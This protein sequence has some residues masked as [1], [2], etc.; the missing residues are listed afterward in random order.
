L[1]NKLIGQTNFIVAIATFII[2]L[3][4]FYSQTSLFWKSFVAAILA[5]ALVWMAYVICHWIVMVF[6]K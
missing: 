3:L 1:D 5:S 2:G 6:K 4:L